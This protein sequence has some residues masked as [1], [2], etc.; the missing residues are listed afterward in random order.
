MP[1]EVVRVEPVAG[2]RL[3]LAFRNGEQR[4][5]DIS[6]LVP[7]EG[8]FKPLEDP[9]YFRRVAVNADIG[10]IAWPN[11]ADICPDVLYQESRAVG[12]GHAA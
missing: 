10:S 2:H 6:R 7:F 4:E 3:V 8:V 9:A 12:T 5:I 1:H 11:G